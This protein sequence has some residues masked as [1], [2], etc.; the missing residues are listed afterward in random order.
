MRTTLSTG[1]DGIILHRLLAYYSEP[2]TTLVLKPKWFP[3]VSSPEQIAA[4]QAAAAATQT[5]AAAQNAA[6]SNKNTVSHQQLVHSCKVWSCTLLLYWKDNVKYCTGKLNPCNTLSESIGCLSSASFSFNHDD[7]DIKHTWLICLN[8]G[9][10]RLHSPVGSGDEEQPS[11]ARGAWCPAYPHHGQP[12][13]LTGQT[14]H[15]DTVSNYHTL[16]Y[17]KYT[18][19]LLL[20]EF[21]V[22]LSPCLSLEVRWWHLQS[23]QFQQ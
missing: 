8:A 18:Q 21:V 15:L 7:V 19:K 13:L 2:G 11:P 14:F 5:I 12:E 10:S 16:C 3:F 23:Q 6:A 9:G 22:F 20:C 17:Q 1:H 4:K